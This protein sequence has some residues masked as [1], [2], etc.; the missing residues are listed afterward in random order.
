MRIVVNGGTKIQRKLV[1]E[2][3]YYAVFMLGMKRLRSLDI[4]INLK[5][6][7][8]ADGYCLCMDKREFEIEANKKMG[9]R[10]L[11]ETIAHEMV[12]VK[13]YARGELTETH[14][15]WKGEP[16]DEN[17]EYWD[18]P[19]EIEAHGRETGLFV[20]FCQSFGYGNKKWA[21]APL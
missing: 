21:Q 6:L 19:W 18:L 12:H 2:M 3:A 13:Q 15:A 7:D 17:T 4:E 9:L 5:K 1:Q 16:V 20:R 14:Y 8:T 11:L 10:R